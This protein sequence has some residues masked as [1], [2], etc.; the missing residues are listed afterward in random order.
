MKLP[1]KIYMYK[2]SVIY[3]MVLILK[4]MSKKPTLSI[5]ELYQQ[6]KDK[7]L[8]PDFLDTVCCLY[9][10]DKI[11]YNNETKSICYVETNQM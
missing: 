9:A 4:L 2:Q 5:Y 10:I 1:N 11:E 6:V 3:D 8:M 7:I